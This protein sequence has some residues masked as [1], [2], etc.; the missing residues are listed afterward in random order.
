MVEMTDALGE[1]PQQYRRLR[2][3]LKQATRDGDKVLYLLT[4]LPE[5]AADAKLIAE[6]YRLRWTIE[7]AFQELEAHLHSE[8][9]TLGH[10]KA[11][12][13]GFCVALIAY[14]T[15][16]VVKASLRSVHGENK[17]AN[18]VSGFYL[19]GHLARTN[20]GMMIAVEEEQ[21]QIFQTMN[22]KT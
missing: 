10:P 2:V 4:N 14:N 8:I 21:W 15:L 3:V 6:M 9:N 7:T 17:I 19:A 12:L 5:S 13:F 18:G 22:E 20:D 16:A 1:N 11:A